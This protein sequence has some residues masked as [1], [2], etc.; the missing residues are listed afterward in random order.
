MICSASRV[1]S[2]KRD[3][4]QNDCLRSQTGETFLIIVGILVF[5]ATRLTIDA[6]SSSNLKAFECRAFLQSENQILHSLRIIQNEIIETFQFFTLLR[7][8]QTLIFLQSENSI[9]NCFVLK[10]F[11]LSFIFLPLKL[12]EPKAAQKPSRWVFLWRLKFH[13]RNE[14]FQSASLDSWKLVHLWNFKLHREKT[15]S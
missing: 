7:N 4:I 8:F 11:F 14:N 2:Q 12:E 10:F 9:E 13:N 15:A 6:L 1:E 5:T 3:E